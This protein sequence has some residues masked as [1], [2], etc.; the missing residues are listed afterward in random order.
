MFLDV[1]S[2]NLT[3]EDAAVLT[4]VVIYFA[5]ALFKMSDRYRP[6]ADIS[7]FAQ[8]FFKI[9]HQPTSGRFL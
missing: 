5:A 2:R 4:Q 8:L 3:V 1:L 6:I 9:I 7:R